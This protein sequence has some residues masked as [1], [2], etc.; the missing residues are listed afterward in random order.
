MIINNYDLK[1][2]NK[3]IKLIDTRPLWRNTSQATVIIFFLPSQT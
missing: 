1:K 3:I 2:D